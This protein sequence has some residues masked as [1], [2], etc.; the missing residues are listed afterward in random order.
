MN[1]K[2]NREG[3]DVCNRCR[4]ERN[5]Y[6]GDEAE[7]TPK[8]SRLND[9]DPGPVPHYLP[10]LSHV[11]QMAIAL[12]HPVVSVYK[13]TGGQWKGGSTH[14]ISFFQNPRELFTRIPL[15]PAEISAI[16][17]KRKHI[18]L[19]S[20]S[21]F[22]LDVDR[23][24][25]WIQYLRVYNRWYRDVTIDEEAITIYQELG[26]DLQTQLTIEDDANTV[27]AP[28]QRPDHGPGIS[29]EDADDLLDA[30]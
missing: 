21:T 11:E 15:L 4:S 24:I 17:V 10:P 8:F 5:R 12:A 25:L 7:F 26:P 1:L 9:L 18:N 14:C 16:I 19:P 23:L 28:N 27:N 30:S 13:V 2:A 3:F 29:N 22:R 6:S 20:H